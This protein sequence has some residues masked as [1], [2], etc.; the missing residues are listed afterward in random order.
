MTLDDDLE[1]EIYNALLV[2]R[3][4]PAAIR[5]LV[6]RKD[7]LARYEIAIV[8]YKA[9]KIVRKIREDHRRRGLL[10]LI[11]G[12]GLAILGSVLLIWLEQTGIPR[13]YRRDPATFALG[14]CIVGALMTA[15]GLYKILL[16]NNFDAEW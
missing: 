7:I 6:E 9:H 1:V 16:P 5:Y 10:H 8:E 2:E 12:I 4:I 15:W 3:T 13:G 14:L 11:S